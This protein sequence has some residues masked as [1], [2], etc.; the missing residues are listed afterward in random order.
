[1]ATLE[2]IEQAYNFRY[3]PLYKQ[4]RDN[5]MLN[6]GRF[7]PDWFTTVYPLLK[8]NPPL[9]LFANDF[10][11][12]S[13]DEIVHEIEAFRSPDDYRKTDPRHRFIPF[14]K[15]GAGDLYCFYLNEQMK[16][17][18]PIVLVWHD[19]G[20]ATYEA[21]NIQDF[22]FLQMLF[23]V[24]DPNDPD[25]DFMQGI[26]RMLQT[27]QQYLTVPQADIV[28]TIYKR[29]H[30][31]ENGTYKDLLSVSELNEILSETA[32]HK[33]QQSFTYTL[34]DP[35]VKETVENKRRTGLLALTIMLP[36]PAQL[37]ELLK[38]LNW[39]PANT[40]NKKVQ[41]LHRKNSVLFGTPS[42]STVDDTF[43]QKLKELKNKFPEQ[44][45]L[46][47][48]DNETGIVHEL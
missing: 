43:R 30:L 16:E 37:N 41:V 35:P 3:P 28:S 42:L 17:D 19:T 11:I 24:I 14:A 45:V 29:N 44:L 13:P 31:D 7:G 38:T 39:R 27:H 21:G 36:I 2:T 23:A 4:L 9:L 46:S 33:Y 12:L 47:F 26:E 20:S 34:P 40:E 25:N 32:F 10:V 1:M 15:T 22:I 8:D 6:W 48:T 18:I 5:N